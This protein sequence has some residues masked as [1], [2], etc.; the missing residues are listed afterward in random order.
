[1]ILDLLAKGVTEQQILN[2]HPE[3]EREDI[4]AALLYAQS[5][6]SDSEAQIE[7]AFNTLA[8]QWKREV[9]A[10]SSIQK[11]VLNPNY[12]RIIGMGPRVLPVILRSL[13][14]SSSHWFWALTSITGENPIPAASSKPFA[15]SNMNPAAQTILVNHAN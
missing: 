13:K 8:L 15:H 1:M 14:E 2:E 6:I 12:Q 4:R 3:L 11:M 9:A 5:L 10:V 7:A